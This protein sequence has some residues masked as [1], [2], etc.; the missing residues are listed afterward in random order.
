[1]SGLANIHQWIVNASQHMMRSI[2]RLTSAEIGIKTHTHR[3]SWLNMRSIQALADQ[4]SISVLLDKTLADLL[5]VLV[6]YRHRLVAL[7]V[8]S[9]L[10]PVIVLESLLLILSDIGRI[11]PIRTL[12]ALHREVGAKFHLLKL[13]RIYRSRNI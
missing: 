4:V 2:L 8:L 7:M 1:M 13:S 3:I 6:S 9:K 11:V 10:G 12:L 5:H